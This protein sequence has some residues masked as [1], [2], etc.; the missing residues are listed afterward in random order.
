[1][2]PYKSFCTAKETI[3][4]T[5]RQSS[6]WEK[7]FAS[8]V[9]NKGLVSKIYKQL[10]TLNIKKINNPIKKWAE[11]LNRLFS[12]ENIQIVKK[13]MKRCST[14]LIVQFSSVQ[15][16]SVQSL[17]R[18]RLFATPWIAACQA[19]LSIT[20]SWSLLKLMP[21]ESVMPSSHLILCRPLLLLPPIPLSIREMQI[22][23]IV[24]YHFTLVRMAIIKKSANNK[25]WT[26]CGEKGTLQHCWWECK[27]VL[28][29]WTVWRFFKKLNIE[30]SLAVQWLEL[31]T[32]AAGSSGSSLVG[33]QDT[34]S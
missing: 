22:K 14:S 11:Y 9:T 20:H 32:F 28:P 6:E 13:H 19:S 24:R 16:S 10:M 34:T 31:H 8:K 18:V 17:S 30:N 33:I 5:K 3:N 26:E 27:L 29:I 21:I 25:C 1:M 2:R 4:K 12:K 15:F 7:I 23:A